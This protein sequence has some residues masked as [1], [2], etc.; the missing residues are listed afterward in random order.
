M[1]KGSDDLIGFCGIA[2]VLS[3]GETEIG[4]WLRP[5][6]WHRGLAFEAASCVERAA[7]D[8]HGVSRLVARAYEA[9]LPSVRLIRKLGMTFARSLDPTPVGSVLLFEKNAPP[10]DA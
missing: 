1:E 6:H 4:W 5:S 9:N 10:V 7:F 3:M 2:P 8:V